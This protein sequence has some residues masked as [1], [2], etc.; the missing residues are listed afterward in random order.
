MPLQN[1][2]KEHIMIKRFN[3]KKK[4]EGFD[5]NLPLPKGG[6]IARILKVEIKENSKGQYLALYYDIAQGTYAGYWQ[7]RFDSYDGADKRWKGIIYVNI[8]SDDDP[9]EDSWK[10]SKF[11]A[12]I[13][14]MERSNPGFE[15]DWNE[16]HFV[17]LQIGAIFNLKDIAKDN[18]DT[19]RITNFVRFASI[20]TILSNSFT[21][22]KDYIQDQE[23][24]T[25]DFTDGDKKKADISDL[26]PVKDISNT[27]VDQTGHDAKEEINPFADQGEKV[28]GDDQADISNP[29]ISLNVPSTPESADELPFK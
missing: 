28:I 29:F 27:F 4:K 7:A 10:M 12:F 25:N 17:G 20:D 13:T 1:G 26:F 8:P 22:P 16:Q 21:Q 24:V 19:V 9:K 3:F 11:K 5:S 15:F 14:S 6:Y 18:G 23:A 2:R